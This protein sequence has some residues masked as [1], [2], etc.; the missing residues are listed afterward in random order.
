MIGELLDNG[1]FVGY[2]LIVVKGIIIRKYHWWRHQS[3][4]C[5]FQEKVFSGK[6]HQCVQ[7]YV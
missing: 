4:S 7:L 2:Y 6:D 3:T 1:A 5:I